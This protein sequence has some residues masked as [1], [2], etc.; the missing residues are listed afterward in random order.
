MDFVNLPILA[1]ALLVFVSV[2]AGLFSVRI[3]F[4]SLLVFLAAGMLAGEDGP[5]GFRFDDL[6]LS[7]WIGNLAL[8]VILLDGGLRTAP[9]RFRTGL[10]P[11]LGLATIGVL[12]CAGITALAGIWFV[13]LDWRSALLL[14]SIIGSTDAAAVFALLTR[15]GVKLNERVAATLEIE[16]GMNDPMAIYLTLAFIALLDPGASNGA[17][18]P[19]MALSFAQQF[20]WGTAT[21]VAGGLGMAAVLR[22]VA[23]R[24]AESGILAL[25]IVAG[26]L[27][28]FA[29]T[30]LVGGSGFL[31]VYLFGL[32]VARRAADAVAPTLA[33]MDGYAWL[34]Q[35]G[36]F[37]LLGLLVTPS[38]LLAAAGPALAVVLT[39]ILVARPIAVWLCLLP[40]RFT[41]RQ[42]WFISWVG[43]R[44]AVP[45]V[46]ALFPLLANTPQ[47]RLLFD[48]AFMVVLA[49]LMTQGSTIALMARKLGVALPD[50]ADE[51][52]VRAMFRDFPIDPATT[53]RDLCEFYGLP[54]PG[55]AE[56]S[57]G[58]WMAS[59]LGL[60]PVAGDLVHLGPATLAVR[61]VE[62]G[63]IS[64]VGLGL[65][66]ESAPDHRR[67]NKPP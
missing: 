35:A 11:A 51:R 50:A 25:L 10:R 12:L 16:S 42:T 8:A 57:L 24:R 32:V 1:A 44:G 67:R 13:G 28:V 31:A 18:W 17:G 49:S 21:G 26:G 5:G 20:G 30:G 60:P 41:A 64:R 9:A 56:R 46:L 29:A 23:S 58:D 39:L 6:R 52:Q 62:G 19:A 40:F 54:E 22:T 33:A 3:G 2:L 55:E 48:I 15:S 36:M 4:S 27:S 7:F 65:G 59:E 34:A 38:T 53:V 47:A 66:P 14:G 45:I 37:L 63:R 61:E 43:L